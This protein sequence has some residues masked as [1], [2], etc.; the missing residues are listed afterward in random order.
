MILVHLSHRMISVSSRCVVDSSK[1]L[2]CFLD[3]LQKSAGVVFHTHCRIKRTGIRNEYLHKQYG[4]LT[5]KGRAY[6]AWHWLINCK[7]AQISLRHLVRLF[8]NS[9]CVTGR[10]VRV[11]HSFSKISSTILST[12]CYNKLI[13]LTAI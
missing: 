2:S 8:R 6:P 1:N 11:G 12:V 9:D 13:R 10:I 5:L 3:L 7:V 4:L